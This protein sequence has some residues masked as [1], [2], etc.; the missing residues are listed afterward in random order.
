MLK[1]VRSFK[2]VRSTFVKWTQY[3]QM[4]CD[5]TK[6]S[7]YYSKNKFFS[8]HAKL[9]CLLLIMVYFASNATAPALTAG[10]PQTYQNPYYKT[11]CG[12]GSGR[13]QVTMQ[14]TGVREGF[15]TQEGMKGDVPQGALQLGGGGGGA[16]MCTLTATAPPAGCCHPAPLHLTI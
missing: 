1:V 15:N 2:A 16:P 8:I 11:Q 7:I 14:P 13:T 12:C 4:S 10:G 6:I 9:Y 3:S 5:I